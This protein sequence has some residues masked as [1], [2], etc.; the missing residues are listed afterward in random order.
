MKSL[1]LDRSRIETI[2]Q[3][4]FSEFTVKKEDKANNLYIYKFNSSD[5]KTAS[6]NVYYN[7]D[8]TTTLMYKTG[9]NQELSQSIAQ[10]VVKHCSIIEHKVGKFYIKA[11]REQDVK[12]VLDFLKE[13]GGDVFENKPFAQGTKYKVRGIQGDEITIHHYNNKALMIQGR[14]RKLF[15]DVIV[16]LGELLP[17][18]EVIEEQLKFYN[19]N[20]TSADAIGELENRMPEAGKYLEDKLKTI[21]SPCLVFKKIDVPLDDYTA[22]AFPALKGIEGVLKQIFREKGIIITKE[23]F[24]E[25]I[26]N[27][28]LN[29]SLIGEAKEKFKNIKTASAICNLYSFYNAQRHPLFHVD[30]LVASTKTLSRGEALNLIESALNLIENSIQT[31]NENTK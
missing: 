22:F 20:V 27:K 29:V 19:I 24:G 28:A 4:H 12:A 15:S 21:L 23:G 6:L 10:T 11:I 25:Y 16:L 17:F 30:G 9:A 26:E 2:F 13:D 31:I 1:T 8:G 7:I 3:E 5:S 14:P 18:K